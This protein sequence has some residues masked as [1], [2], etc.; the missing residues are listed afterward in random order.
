MSATAATSSAAHS[1]GLLGFLAWHKTGITLSKQLS[2]LLFEDFS[3]QREDGAPL[4]TLLSCG[5][6]SDTC[7]GSARIQHNRWRMH[8]ACGANDLRRLPSWQR[9]SAETTY[10]THRLVVMLRDAFDV[11]VSSYLY[12]LRSDD[13]KDS[14]IGPAVLESLRESPL[15]A[16]LALQARV[17]LAHD[18][19][20][21]QSSHVGGSGGLLQ[22][23]VAF[24]RRVHGAPWIQLHWLENFT[25]S[26]SS[27]TGEVDRLYAFLLHD[28]GTPER[29]ARLGASA[30]KYDLALGSSGR[31]DQHA[32]EHASNRTATAL[33]RA[34]LLQS[35]E[36]KVEREALR[37][38]GDELA[39][40][41]RAHVA[42][43]GGGVSCRTSV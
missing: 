35:A 27:Y 19:N 8:I 32:R 14:G 28:V 30:R 29:R 38:M 16:G 34:T 26:S 24:V 36:L 37:A 42:T 17:L 7:V 10:R 41:Y 39:G 43:C 31:V 3:C 6:V 21:A 18:A 23:M 9:P 40:L 1:G 20:E 25:R 5:A 4:R 22:Q 12:H 11:V 15:A 13:I 2:T 33:V